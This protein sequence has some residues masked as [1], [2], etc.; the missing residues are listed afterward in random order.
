MKLADVS[1]FDS[2]L[3]SEDELVDLEVLAAL[4]Q[5]ADTVETIEEAGA[6][7]DEARFANR[8]Q[9]RELAARSYSLNALYKRLIR[10]VP[11]S[12]VHEAAEE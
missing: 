7:L 10:F 4:C 2:T 12:L 6:V 3:F 5:N 9:V 8:T 11:R 1:K